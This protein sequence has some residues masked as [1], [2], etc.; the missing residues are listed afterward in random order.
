VQDEETR[1]MLRLAA[2]EE[3]V[4]ETLVARVLPRL[5]GYFRHL[6]ADAALAEDCAQDVLWKVYRAREGYRPRAKFITYLFHVARNHWI[7]VYRHRRAG[8]QVV[9][10]LAGG[11]D[12]EEGVMPAAAVAPGGGSPPDEAEL[13]RAL[14]EAIA[15][16]KAEL[17]EVYVLAQGGTLRYQEIA[18]ILGMPLGTVK[19][20]MHAAIRQV[21][22]ALEDRGWAPPGRAG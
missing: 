17:R 8:P 19:S 5:L 12:D 6:G 22:R 7:D 13:R 14:E 9:S 21:Q 20:R 18:E 3:A 10:R 1:L 11:D 2:G 4:F 16:L 15:G